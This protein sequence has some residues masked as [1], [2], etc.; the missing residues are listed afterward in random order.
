MPSSSIASCVFKLAT[1]AIG[2]NPALPTLL[3]A[4]FL[5]GT[6]SFKKGE[7]CTKFCARL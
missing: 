6:V 1:T 5:A 3:T 4:S 2:D 7:F